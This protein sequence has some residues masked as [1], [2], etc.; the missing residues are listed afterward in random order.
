GIRCQ[1]AHMGEY[2]A[3]PSP[4]A[5]F[6]ANTTLAPDDVMT[7]PEDAGTVLTAVKL[8]WLLAE[9]RGRNRPDAPP[10]AKAGLPGPPGHA[11]PLRTEETPAEQRIQAQAVL[12][13]LARNLGVD[14][15][16]TRPSFSRALDNQA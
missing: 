1:A 10:G 2:W 8:G 11:L 16:E 6:H 3:T 13:V 14:R 15:A 7:V 4:M 12:A 5:G 9:V